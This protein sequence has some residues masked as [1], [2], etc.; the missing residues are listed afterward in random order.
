ML[1]C[2]I[3]NKFYF[4]DK[5]PNFKFFAANPMRPDINPE[6]EFAYGSG[7]IN[8]SKAA[9]HGLVYDAVEAD[10]INLLCG[11][12]YSTK[13]LQI[14]TGNRKSSCRKSGSARLASDLINYPAFVLSASPSEPINHVFNRTVTNVGSPSSTYKSNLVAPPGLKITV[15][16]D[17]LAFSS[18]GEK[19]SYAVTVQGTMDQKILVSASL[20][21]DD[22]TYQVRSP[23]IV[24]VPM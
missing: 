13:L 19:R 21:W 2:K 24:Y 12:G 16:P 5:F 15:S 10:Y 11:Q 4:E 23:I 1:N 7:Q 3:V 6:A 17:V 20:V 18:L 22:G 8:P 14:V 9:Y